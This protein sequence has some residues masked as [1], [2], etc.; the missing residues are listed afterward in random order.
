M[1]R[2]LLTKNLSTDP[3]LATVRAHFAEHGVGLCNAAGLIEGDAGTARVLR[4]MSGL[5]EASC[6]N[7]T[8][9]RMLVDL[10]RLLSL[11]LVIEGSEPD[12]S[13]WI[14]LDQ[15]SIEVGEICLTTDL[16]YQLLIDIGGLDDKR[17]AMALVLQAQEVA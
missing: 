14:L 15:G 5:R 7:R 16:L 1:L 3:Q 8:I 2:I 9:R 11:D 17:D 4:L 13:S 10:H 12:L 6:L